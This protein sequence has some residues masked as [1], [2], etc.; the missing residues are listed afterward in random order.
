LSSWSFWFVRSRALINLFQEVRRFSE[1]PLS[2]F[3]MPLQWLFTLVVPIAF[4]GFYPSERLLEV[5][6]LS[7]L[8]WLA[9]PLGLA[10]Y[11]VGALVWHAGLARYQGTGS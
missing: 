3:P 10:T 7:R 2:I 4:A 11:A 5:T 1:Y 8:A 9:L 6:A